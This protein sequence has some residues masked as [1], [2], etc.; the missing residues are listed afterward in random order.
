M[1]VRALLAAAGV[2][3]VALAWSAPRRDAGDDAILR[4]LSAARDRRVPALVCFALPGRE[5]SDAMDRDTWTTTELGAWMRHS[6]ACAHVA[7]PEHAELFERWIGG[8][9]GLATCVVDSRGEAMAVLSGFAEPRAC[10]AF[11]ERALEL[12]PRWIAARELADR[13]ATSDAAAAWLACGEIALELDSLRTARTCLDAALAIG[14]DDGALA[15]RVKERLARL[16]ITCGDLAH[17]RERLAMADPTIVG[18]SLD[19]TNALLAFG[20]RRHAEVR[21]HLDSALRRLEPGPERQRAWTL[22]ARLA[23]ADDDTELELDSLRALLTESPR[24]R[25][26]DAARA[27]A[28]LLTASSPTPP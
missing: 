20:D 10:R 26:S 21:K 3:L 8:P 14:G 7:A 28:A 25:W 22:L 19:L 18:P 24:S 16:D 2:G 4:A 1:Y 17:A 12:W 5:Q 15:A 13:T 27:R 9:P 6:F 11:L 23:R